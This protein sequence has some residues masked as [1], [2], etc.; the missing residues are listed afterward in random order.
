M[1]APDDIFFRPLDDIARRLK[2]RTTTSV[3]LTERALD[4]LEKRGKDLGAVASVMRESALAEAQKADRAI[5]DGRIRGPLHGIP[6]AAKDLFDTAGT[7]TTW[8]AGPYAHRMPQSDATVITKLRDAGAVLTAKLSMAELA[9]GLGYHRGDA[10]LQGPMRNPWNREK[11][12]GGSSSG[13][14]ACVAAGIVPYALGTET[15][16]SIL[17][18][19][20]FNGITGLRPTYGRVSRAGA[21]ALSW[22]FDKVGPLARRASDCRVVLDA[23]AGADLADPTA[24]PRKLEWRDVDRGMRGMR[25]AVVRQ[26]YAKNGDADIAAAFDAALR[27]LENAGL[28]LKD[29]TLPDLPYEA[30]AITVIQADA[31]SAF[32]PLYKTGDVR[33]LVDERAPLQ[34]EVSKAITGADLVKCSRLRSEMQRAMNRFFADYDV[35][36]SPNFLR[37]APGIAEDFDTAFKGGD[38]VGGMGNACGLPAIALPMGFTRDKLPVGFQVVAPAF[39][40]HVAMRVALAYQAKTRWHEERPPSA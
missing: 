23:I 11:W 16:G 17:C 2:L 24:A 39:E 7:L 34:A 26:D 15:W 13:S 19:A 32:E 1:S 18:P 30:V 31:V 27:E 12:A 33:K 14:G 29:T 40:E 10:S 36:V 38:P 22:T 3:E 8:G 20:A 5:E 25:A 37:G 9:G 4:G 6:Y 28:E 35:I 21:M